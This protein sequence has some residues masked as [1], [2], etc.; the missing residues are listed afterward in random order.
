MFRGTEENHETPVTFI[1]FLE[2]VSIKS[3]KV[4][5]I[6]YRETIILTL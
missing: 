3:T 4:H 2:I 5:G 6:T 1:F